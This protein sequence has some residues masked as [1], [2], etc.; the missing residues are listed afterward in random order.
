MRATQQ[1]LSSGEPWEAERECGGFIL[2]VERYRSLRSLDAALRVMRES[3]P[4]PQVVETVPLLQAVGR[5]CAEPLYAQYSVPGVRSAGM[6]GYAVRSGDTSGAREQRPIRLFQYA[7]INTGDPVPDEYDAIVPFEDVWKCGDA[8]E[9]R[10]SVVPFQHVHQVGS[11]ARSGQLIIPRGH[12]IRP[13][14]LGSL[15]AYGHTN[16]PVRTVRVGIIA[17]GNELVAPGVQPGPGQVI[18]NNTLVSKAYLTGMGASCRDYGIIPDDADRIRTTLVE[19]AA[20]NDLVLISA[21]MSIGRRDCTVDTIAS[22]GEIIFHGVAISPGKLM[23]LGRISGKPVLGL[24]GYPLAAQTVLREFASRLLCWWGLAPYPEYTLTA[25]IAH[26]VGSELGSEDFIPVSVANVGGRC[27]AVQHPR[28]AHMQLT[29]L[30][31]NGYLHVPSSAEGWTAG[32][33]VPVHLTVHPSLIDRAF[34]CVGPNQPPLDHLANLLTDTGVYLHCC[35]AGNTGAVIAL[36]NNRCH[37]ATMTMIWQGIGEDHA[38]MRQLNGL[39]CVR[40]HLGAQELGIAASSA[41]PDMNDLST[42]SIVNR[43]RDSASRALLDALLRQR[44]VDPST[45]AGYDREVR[46]HD[47]VAA[48]VS[49]GIASMGVCT[50]TIA[51][52]SGL[53]FLPLTRESYDLVVRPELLDEECFSSILTVIRSPGYISHLPESLRCGPTKIGDVLDIKSG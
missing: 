17:T 5:V 44:S 6:D 9:I 33:E 49:Q 25:R 16:I 23:L 27:W 48:A 46:S 2:L 38:V 42:A 53:K 30:R 11:D 52:E 26:N 45:V 4:A 43:Q 20:E 21:G 28:G 29:M 19:A 18:E 3:F 34:L 51:E 41:Q 22:L 10:K 32:T 31:S 12:R 37:A 50:R 35:T 47:A 14:D 24:P 1:H 39:D 8:C 7:P 15:A 13:F 36:K 40:I